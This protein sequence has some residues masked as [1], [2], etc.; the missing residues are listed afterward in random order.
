MLAGQLALILAAASA[1]AAF[2]VNFAEHPTCSGQYTRG[3][4]G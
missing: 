4:R 2:Y 3:T 1:G